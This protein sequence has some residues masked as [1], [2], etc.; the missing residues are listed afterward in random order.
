M[1]AGDFGVQVPAESEDPVLSE[2]VN[3]LARRLREWT[4]QGR[5][6]AWG[7]LATEVTGRGDM[8]DLLRDFQSNLRH[9]AWQAR[10]AA[11]GDL[12]QNLEAMGDL[13]TV[14]GSMLSQL[15]E[16][17]ETLL[18]KSVEQQ[19]AVER[20][21]KL[22]SGQ[23]RVPPGGVPRPQVSLDGCHRLLQAAAGRG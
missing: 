12:T 19:E 6:L 15:R 2:A 13:S 23:G 21:T 1:A 17:Q 3:A 7:N 5:D 10:V 22:K 14:F 8:A 16:M 20:L 18:Q 4:Q 11:S 9:L